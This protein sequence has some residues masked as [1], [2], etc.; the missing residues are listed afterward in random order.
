[1]E[2]SLFLVGLILQVSLSMSQPLDFRRPGCDDTLRT[3]AIKDIRAAQLNLGTCQA[4]LKA[5]DVEDIGSFDNNA[6]F[7]GT[8]PLNWTESQNFCRRFN[9]SLAVIENEKVNNEIKNKLMKY[10]NPYGLGHLDGFW[11][12]GRWFND[13]TWI[14]DTNDNLKPIVWFDW[15]PFEPQSYATCIQMWTYNGYQ[16]DDIGCQNKRRFLCQMRIG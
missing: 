11:I 12:G 13:T 16:W 5:M 15:A 2:C 9:A 8:S 3:K 6:I 10:Q 14:W 1:M 4:I 7:T